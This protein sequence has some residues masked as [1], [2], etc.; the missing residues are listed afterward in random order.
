MERF[1]KALKKF[2]MILDR[3]AGLCFA[4][5]MLLIIANI[6]SRTVFHHPILGTYE[7]V[8]FL[9]AMGVGFALAYCAL[10]DGH[11]S[12][13]FVVDRFS[14]KTQAIIAVLINALSA[15]FM[16]AAGCYLVNYGLSMKLNGSVSLSAEI[17]IYPFIFMVAVGVFAL[18]LILFRQL[19]LS[20]Q[21]LHT[22]DEIKRV[23]K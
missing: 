12:V 11:I 23:L 2:S 6:V 17:P 22:T 3:L 18:S 1:M 8:G 16:F 20:C 15:V 19:Y 21:T 5:V 13:S 4:A 10:Q 14:L 9:T 7:M